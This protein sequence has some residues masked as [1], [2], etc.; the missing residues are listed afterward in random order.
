[1]VVIVEMRPMPPK[2][3]L[4]TKLFI[5][6]I[7]FRFLKTHYLKHCTQNLG[8]GWIKCVKGANKIIGTNLITFIAYK[9]VVLT[10]MNMWQ[11]V[12]GQNI[13]TKIFIFFMMTYY[14]FFLK[15]WM[16]IIHDYIIFKV[17]QV[18]QKMR[19]K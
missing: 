16:I 12:I 9:I 6:V 10:R 13:I 14:N 11:I 1:V 19:K 18:L 4:E 5:K 17:F 2:R 3:Y 7:P 15:A 8:K